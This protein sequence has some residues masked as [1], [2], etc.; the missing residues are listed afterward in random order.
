MFFV[1]ILGLLLL[2]SMQ[3]EAKFKSLL[4]V[5]HDKDYADFFICKINAISRYKNS[6]SIGYRIKQTFGSNLILRMELF[7]RANGWRPFLYN[8]TLNVCDFLDNAKNRNTPNGA[9]FSLAFSYFSQYLNKPLKCPFYAN[10]TMEIMNFVCNMKRFR[11]RFPIENGE[12]AAQFSVYH[13]KILK[14]TINGSMEYY[15]YKEH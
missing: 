1:W 9:L 2:G 12:Y 4:C 3:V 8:V 10:D 7:K 5:P 15:N 13:K 6:I 14:Y 11:S